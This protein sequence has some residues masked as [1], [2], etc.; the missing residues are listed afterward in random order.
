MK[1]RTRA[2][3][4]ADLEAIARRKADT[5]KWVRNLRKADRR[6]GASVC[7]L[8]GCTSLYG[9]GA[10]CSWANAARTVCTSC[11]LPCP[12]C[13]S[14]DVDYGATGPDQCQACDGL[15]R[16]GLPLSDPGGIKVE[17]A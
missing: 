13:G 15:F 11:A 1:A 16:F 5:P 3:V 6:R 17:R 9:C 4:L 2:E 14:P 12:H 7:T 10:G 8:C